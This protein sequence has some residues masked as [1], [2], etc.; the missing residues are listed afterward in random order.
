MSTGTAILGC[1]NDTIYSSDFS[2]PYSSSPPLLQS[3][4]IRLAVIPHCS[5]LHPYDRDDLVTRSL[6]IPICCS[7][8]HQPLFPSG[9]KLH[10]GFTGL[11]E[12]ISLMV[13]LTINTKPSTKPKAKPSHTY[14]R[15]MC[16]VLGTL[17]FHIKAGF[18][19]AVI[20]PSFSPSPSVVMYDRQRKPDCGQT[21]K[22][23]EQGTRIS[24]SV[25][26]K[27]QK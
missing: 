10:C 18:W 13:L 15:Y 1:H 25:T 20:I 27:N 21:L 17:G 23:G 24:T 2:C 5:K 9:T 4:K 14:N 22:T 19:H 26:K 7:T 6:W 3:L 16:I 8:V 12:P 11:P